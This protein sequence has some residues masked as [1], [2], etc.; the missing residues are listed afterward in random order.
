M[1]IYAVVAGL[2]SVP[3]ITYIIYGHLVL[4]TH[5]IVPETNNENYNI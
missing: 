2:T 5:N 3:Y 1:S 4:H